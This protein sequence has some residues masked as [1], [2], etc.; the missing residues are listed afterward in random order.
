[1][2]TRI[3]GLAAAGCLVAGAAQAQISDGIV[4]IGVLTDM[5]GLYSAP[6]GPGSVL[7]AQLAVADFG[8]KVAGKKIEIVFG[9]HLNKAD[10]GASI[11]RQ[12]IDQDQVDA[13]VDVPTS[14]VALAVQ[15]ITREKNRVFLMSGAA[16]SDL[17]GKA[18]SPTGVQWTYDTYALAHG[19]GG[20]LAKQG[21][22]TWFFLTADYAF[23]Q[24]LERDTAAVVTAAGGKVLGSIRVPLNTPDFSSFL[25]QA[26]ASQ[27]KIIGLANAGGDTINAIKQAS[28]YGIAAGGQRLAGLLVNFNDIHSLGLQAAQGLVL[29]EAFYWDQNEETR[30]WSKRFFAETKRMPTMIQAGVYGAVTHYLK[31]I[32]AAKTDEAKAVIAKMR[33]LPINDFM[34]KNGKLREDGR[35]MRDMYLFQVKAPSESKYP[36]DYYKQLATIPAEQAFRP[37]AEGECPFV[38]KG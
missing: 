26:Q 37:L 34:T 24:A 36:F 5:S 38:K 22:D 19:T 14:S 2:K 29:T 11:A 17:T 30:A 28:E 31:A 7:G 23:G 3:I 25:L 18:C 9:D 16:A 35:V 12:W 8:G 33:E 1:M 20:A 21:G 4:K 6:T 13:I 15:D 10:A 32:E 27:A